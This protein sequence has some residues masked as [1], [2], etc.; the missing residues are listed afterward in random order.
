[1]SGMSALLEP[2]AAPPVQLRRPAAPRG[3]ERLMLAMLQD[4]VDCFQKYVDTPDSHS[5]HLFLEAYRW[6][7]C[8]DSD[9]PFSFDNVCQ[10]LRISPAYV[11]RGLARLTDRAH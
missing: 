1:M 8:P 4:A 11:R 5:Q 2:G 3:E 10:T 9:W 6:I 7:Y